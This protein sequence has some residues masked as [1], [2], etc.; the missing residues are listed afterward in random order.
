MN[1]KTIANVVVF[2]ALT[3]ALNLWGPKIPAPYATYLIYQVWEI[4]IVAAFLL[5]GSYVGILIAL[6]NTM[7][8]FAVFPGPLPSG[9]FYNFAAVLSTL[10]GVYLVQKMIARHSFRQAE[11]I[12]ATSSTVLGTTLRVGVMTVV[13]WALL[14]YPWPIG[15]NLTE[16]AILVSLPLTGLF[17]ATL[18]LYTIP[19]GHVIAK[20]VRSVIKTL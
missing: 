8:L 3:V 11:L 6:I 9:P 19:L 1:S 12:A 17:N 4:P 5:F 7:I 2:A 15:Y 16:E 13:N 20:T 18:A 14:R 10:F